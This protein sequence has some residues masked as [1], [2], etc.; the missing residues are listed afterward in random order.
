M[1]LELKPSKTRLTHTLNKVG[2]EQPGFDFLGFNIRQFP[3]G[4]YTTGKNT[5]GGPLGFATIIT[6]SKEKVEI[7]LKEIGQIIDTHR[8]AP[9]AGLIK[10]LNLV[11]KGWA[12]YY[13]SVL[14]TKH[15]SKL[16]HL[17]YQ[18]LRAWANRRHP[19][20]GEKWV[21]DKY[22]Q[23]IDGDNWV[24]ATR[25]ASLPDVPSGS[26]ARRQEGTNPLRLYK[27]GQTKRVDHVKVKGSSSPYDGNL[28]Y[29]ST[30][31]GNNPEMPKRVATLLKRQKGKCAHCGLHF[32]DFD[33][34]E[35]DHK[36]PKSIGG[37]DSY[38]NWDLLHRHCH[39]TKTANDG[40]P[41]TKSDCNSVKPKPP[42]KPQ[43]FWIEDMLVMRY[44]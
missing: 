14:S 13:R 10:K 33:V 2:K 7:H 5:Y 4:K 37:K 6:P 9:Q 36:I 25:R 43:W 23:S 41:G 15:F 21:S 31:M 1:G 38:D 20:K 26:Q 39:D 27:H 16:D 29:W 40:S 11:I 44:A 30:R 22:W 3:A 18:K 32:R 24:F 8:A 28:V 34:L 12:N 17:V 42:S 19:D 35:V